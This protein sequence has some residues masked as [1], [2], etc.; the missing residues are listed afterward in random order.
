LAGLVGVNMIS[1]PGMLDFES[2]QSIE[3][4][5]ID[6]E[7]VG[8]VKRFLGGVDDHGSPFAADILKD[9]DKTQELLSHPSTLQLF[10]KELFLP[11]PIIARM[12]REDWKK[13]GSLSA[14]RRARQQL[15]QHL[16]K[17]AQQAIDNTIEK[18]IEKI[19][20]FHLA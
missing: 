15:E 19:I 17:P 12:T 9:Y 13:T 7:I 20:S 1:G 8:M 16:K 5:L 11:S 14:R 18:E 4:L 10:R 6:N 3:K 2:C